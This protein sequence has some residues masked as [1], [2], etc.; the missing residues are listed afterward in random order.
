MKNKKK[1]GFT[2]IEL[3]AVIAILAILG[4]ILVPRISG[5]T[6]KANRSKDLA[7]A[8]QLIQAV[9]LYNQ[10][11]PDAQI[12]DSANLNKTTLS[13]NVS[14]WPKDPKTTVDVAAVAANPTATPPVEAVDPITVTSTTKWTDLTVAQLRLYSAEL[15]K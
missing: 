1:K 13:S 9:E 15:E 7:N 5:Y 10:D 11:H 8:K 6:A 3:I 14:S 12:A 2:L 4:V